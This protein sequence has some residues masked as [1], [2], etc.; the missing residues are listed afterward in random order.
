[1]SELAGYTNITLAHFGASADAANE[2]STLSANM[3]YLRMLDSDAGLINR[4]AQEVDRKRYYEFASEMSNLDYFH[5]S[6]ANYTEVE[7]A[8]I[9]A[10]I[11]RAQFDGLSGRALVTKCDVGDQSKTLLV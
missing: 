4:D 1:M 7:S 8:Q 9:E 11:V 10:C 2:R 6:S 5:F 3:Q